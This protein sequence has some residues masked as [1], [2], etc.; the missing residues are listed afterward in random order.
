MLALAGAAALAGCSDAKPQKPPMERALAA[1][2]DGDGFGAELALREM[3]DSGTPPEALAA[4][5]GQAE[6]LQ[7]QPIEARQWLGD[8]R[9]TKDTAGR[10]FHMLGRL[11]MREG[12]L[13]GAGK[14]FD[15]A[16]KYTPDSP[17]LWVDI[18][19]LRYQGGEQVLA[20]QAA[21]KAVELGPED[22]EALMFRGQLARD[23]DGMVAA[24]P[25]FEKAIAAKPKQLDL[26]SEYAATLGEAG[27]TQDMLQ[28]VRRMTALNPGY[29]RAYYLQAVLAAR[30][31]QYP[32]AR[33]LL[34]RS[35]GEANDTP[36]G[37]LLSGV[38]DLETGNYASA[39]QELDRLYRQQPENR[40][41]R[42]LLARALSMSGS[43]RELIHRFGDS[44]GLTSASPYLQTLVARSYEALGERD[45]AARLI[46]LASRKQPDN[47]VA[48]RPPETFAD[49]AYSSPLSGDEVLELVRAR[50]TGGRTAD[51]MT[52]ANAF[53]ER[54]PGSADALA[55]AGDAQ[56]AGKNV[57]KSLA[58]Y[59]KSASIRQSWPLARRRIMALR[60]AGRAGE[61][62]GLLERFVAGHQTA[63]EPA[64]MLARAQFDQGN[65]PSAAILLDHALLKGGDRDPDILALRAVVALRMGD[66][67]LAR[68]LA[69]RA[70]E[71]QPTHA[72]SLQALAM[73]GGDALS[74][75][76]LAKANRLEGNRRLARR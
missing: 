19:R 51:A 66:P 20:V 67:D 17:R 18:G 27:E 34:M 39:A 48:L 1:L 28:V 58:Y 55:L 42:D 63:V 31:G 56:L 43:D 23:S 11:E 76:L 26:L 22:P 75:V 46:D 16:I 65:F 44:A 7:G 60:A 38:I 40:R 73:V 29:L 71:V 62:H 59:G 25:W 30:G 45:K 54:F 2:E 15:R 12:N 53:L 4:Y 36:A 13:G 52:M 70:F 41:V 37:M 49:G 3:L 72:A 8:G 61:A 5:L 50:I 9:F 24:L 74:G 57:S 47:L 64:A 69:D 33:K 10:G 68:A 6:L 35:G 14:A 32:L 21:I